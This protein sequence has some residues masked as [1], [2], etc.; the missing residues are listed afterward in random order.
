[1]SK[2]DRAEMYRSYL[3]EEGF[4]PKFDS[5][6]DVVFKY[7]GRSYV[8]II[9]ENDEEFFR[10]VFPN[11]WSID[12]DEER[13]KVLMA[14]NYSTAK[15]KVTKIFTVRDDTWAA[16]EM[17]YSPPEAFKIGFRRALSALQTGVNN[18]LEKVRREE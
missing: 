8:I 1:M 17:F 2:Q 9:D 13:D 18:F 5:D 16:I 4:S 15:T 11:F 3:A 7:E 6:G 12:T 10:L 14:A